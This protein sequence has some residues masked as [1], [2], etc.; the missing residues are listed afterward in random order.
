MNIIKNTIEK[1]NPSQTPVDTCDQP[2][3]ILTK[4]LQWWQ[5]LE[6]ENYVS[7]FAGMHIKQSMQDVHGDIILVQACLKFQR[8]LTSLLHVL[9]QL[10]KL[11]TLKV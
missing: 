4:E 9:M 7:L 10:L 3:Y 5:L 2:V 6:F 11:I 8:S 1:L